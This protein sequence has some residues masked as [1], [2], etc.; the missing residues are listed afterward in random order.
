M[1]SSH[2]SIHNPCEAGRALC[3]AR[4]S[5]PIYSPSAH[6]C[7]SSPFQFTGKARAMVCLPPLL[8]KLGGYILSIVSST[9]FLLFAGLVL[10]AWLLCEIVFYFYLRYIVLPELNRLTTPEDSVH[11]P[12]DE[13][14]KIIDV[15]SQLKVC[16]G[17]QPSTHTHAP[18]NTSFLMICLISV[19]CLPVFPFSHPPFLPFSVSPSP[20]TGLLRLRAIF[21]RLVPGLS[22]PRH[23]TRE[24]QRN[25]CLGPLQQ[26]AISLDS[27]A[28]GLCRRCERDGGGWGR[29]KG[30]GV[31]VYMYV[32]ASSPYTFRMHS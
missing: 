4:D 27:E 10:G 29:G 24:C 25:A 26:S 1:Q 9:L 14:H 3:N 13:F 6:P 28:E 32:Y 17:S 7:P 8:I 15:V 12:W 21:L 16:C 30:D 20:C 18:S 19:G 5:G 11:T 22:Y 23:T 31:C 2:P